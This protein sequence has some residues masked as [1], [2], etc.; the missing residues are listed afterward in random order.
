[1]S[2]ISRIRRI[3]PY[4]ALLGASTYLYYSAGQFDFERVPERI[5]PDAWPRM[6][7]LMLMALCGWQVLRLALGRGT[8][9]T[10]GLGQTLVAAVDPT[11]D[12]E[13]PHRP[14]PVW[15]GIGLTFA[16]LLSFETTGFFATSVVYLAAIMFVGGYRRI[17][18]AFAISLVTTLIFVFIFMKL[19]YVS[20]PLGK[21]PFL[22]RSTAV[23]RLLGIH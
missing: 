3:A 12:V 21:G 22:P 11:V 5:G 17:G 18:R 8:S 4:A 19:V 2:I 1:M 6:I 13:P 23:M 10:Q 15:L 7:L 16:Y 9:S 14:L 20:L